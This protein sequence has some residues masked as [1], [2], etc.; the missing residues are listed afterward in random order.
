MDLQAMIISMII[1]LILS[2]PFMMKGVSNGAYRTKGEKI[3][4]EAKKSGRVVEAVLVKKI[5]ITGEP[6]AADRRER[7]SKWWSFYQYEVKGR[8]YKYNV[9]FYEEPPEKLTLYYPAGKPKKAIAYGSE[10]VGA[11]TTFLILLPVFIWAII[12]HIITS[13]QNL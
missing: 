13:G 9:N 11:K 6:N 1:T 12:Y 8:T 2:I 5:F 3:I 4:E 10:V 7:E